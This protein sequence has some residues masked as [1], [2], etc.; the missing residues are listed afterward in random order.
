MPMAD[1]LLVSIEWV[2]ALVGLMLTGGLFWLRE[3]FHRNDKDHDA[4]GKG[5][6]RVQNKLDHIITHHKPQMP[7][8]NDE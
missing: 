8:M 4:I 7:P 3:K 2:L 5:V 1:A 6:E